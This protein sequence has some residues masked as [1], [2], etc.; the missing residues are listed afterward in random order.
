M[1]EKIKET[2]ETITKGVE[3]YQTELAEM[4]KELAEVKT[5]GMVT[6]P[7]QGVMEKK[8]KFYRDVLTH[9]AINEKTDNEGGYAIPVDV[10]EGILDATA[11]H[12]VFR[13]VAS[14]FPMT[15]DK[16]KVPEV[17]ALSAGYVQANEEITGQ[18]PTFAGHT[19]ETQPISIIIPI[20]NSWLQDV[21]PKVVAKIEELA[22]K[23]FAE[24]EDYCTLVGDGTED[25]ENAGVEGILTVCPTGNVV[26][27]ASSGV[28]TLDADDLSDMIDKPSGNIKNGVFYFDKSF[29]S[30]IRKLK[31]DNKYIFSPAAN[32]DVDRI[33]GYEVKWMPSGILPAYSDV[34]A[35][36]AFGVFGDP[37]YVMF[38]DRGSISVASSSEAGFTK[39]QTLV[40]FIKRQA[41]VVSG[42]GFSVIKTK[43]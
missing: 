43:A 35:D 21:N 37:S 31:E 41:I 12:G 14:I 40:R 39:N 34:G 4:K 30:V 32:G 22:I 6:S 11:D 26:T 19:L 5:M 36:E 17:G 33:W 9:K 18:T 23:A 27:L 20:D 28:S 16:V 38:G 2:L 3:S 24:R 7:T 25:Y 1:D 29:R 10:A 42:K 8:V 13:P 15:T